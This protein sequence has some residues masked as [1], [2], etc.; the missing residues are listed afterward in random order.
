[1][2]S[3]LSP[4]VIRLFIKPPLVPLLVLA[5]F[6]DGFWSFGNLHTLTESIATDGIVVAGLTNVMISGGFDLSVGAVMAMGGVA[7]VVLLP[8]G[9]G[10]AIGALFGGGVGAAVG[11]TVGAGVGTAGVLTQRGKDIYLS[12]G[13]HLR[14]RTNADAAIQ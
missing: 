12:N 8:H 13:Q 7:A 11:A 4:V 2:S 14:I 1:M 5:S 3:G 9:I 6:V 10:A